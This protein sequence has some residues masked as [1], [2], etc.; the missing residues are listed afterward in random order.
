MA[1][2]EA[3]F[4]GETKRLKVFECSIRPAS[5][6]CQRNLLK[7]QGLRRRFRLNSRLRSANEI[8]PGRNVNESQISSEE[9]LGSLY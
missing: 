6:R 1:Q 2:T 7:H 5:F 9:S 8:L 4:A 3:A